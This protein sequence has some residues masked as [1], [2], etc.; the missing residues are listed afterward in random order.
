[1]KSKHRRPVGPRRAAVGVVA[2]AVALLATV[3]AVAPASAAR[4]GGGK[5]SPTSSS[6]LTLVPMD[7]DGVVN[8]NDDITFEVST[9]ATDRPF[10][11]VRCYQGEA[12]VYDGYVGYFPDYMFDKNWFTL[13][14]PYWSDGVAASCTARL[15]WFDKRGNEKVLTTLGFTAAP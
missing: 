13:D 8:H 2:G 7:S 4:G 11:G 6:T 5:P 15:F 14:S 1:M 9:T 10:V 12:F 3:A